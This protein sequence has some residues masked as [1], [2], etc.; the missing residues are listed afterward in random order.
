MVRLSYMDNT[1]PSSQQRPTQ[2]PSAQQ[3]VPA[4]T[5]SAAATV[6]DAKPEE[7]KADT[8]NYGAPNKEFGPVSS[9]G[10]P[11]ESGGQVEDPD[12]ED[13]IKVARQEIIHG[14]KVSPVKE[15]PVSQ[16]LKEF[17]IEQGADIEQ[18][19]PVIVQHA[20]VRATST[21]SAI[22]FSAVTTVKLPITYEHA[23][24]LDK[25]SKIKESIKWLARFIKRQWERVRFLEK[26]SGEKTEEL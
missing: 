11:S 14:T 12:D 8:A 3:A 2:P 15:V 22:P 4:P 21:D 26:H 7:K 23:V 13:E 1:L 6:S 5:Q 10:V 9:G 18:E 25:G 16:E 17:G 24:Q 20:G 19:V